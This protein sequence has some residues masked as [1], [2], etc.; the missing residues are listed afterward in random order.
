MFTVKGLLRYTMTHITERDQV[1]EAVGLLIGLEQVKRL[2][3]MYREIVTRSAMLASVPVSLKRLFSLV[4]PICATIVKVPTLPSPTIRANESA[5]APFGI[6][7]S[8]T[9]IVI[10]DLARLQLERSPA[11]GTLNRDALSAYANSMLSLPKTVAVFITEVM[12]GQVFSVAPGLELLS[13]LVTR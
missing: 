3:V 12:L 6:A 4:V 8:I 1:A 9:E 13:T 7:F 10:R 5:L 11:L 2:F